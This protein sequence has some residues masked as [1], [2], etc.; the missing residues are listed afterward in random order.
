MNME[1]IVDPTEAVVQVDRVRSLADQNTEALGFLPER[2]YT[3]AALK[4]HLWIATDKTKQRILGY[5]LFGG[6]FPNLKVFQVYVC[7]KFRGQHIAP[8]L[9]EKLKDYGQKHNFMNIKAKVASELSANKFWQSMGFRII[10]QSPGKTAGR[11]N[12]LYCLELDVPSLFRESTSVDGK[13]TAL[14]YPSRPI[15]E[16]PTFAIDV[17]VLFDVIQDRSTDDAARVITFAMDSEIK[18]CVT[19]EFVRE[20]ENRSLNLKSDPV[21]ALA[22]QL[23]RL[24]KLKNEIISPIIEEIRKIFVSGTPKT[25]K[26]LA[27]DQSDFTH[28]ASCI[29]HRVHGFVTRDGAILRNAHK[30]HEKYSLRI[31]SPA[32]VIESYEEQVEIDKAPIAFNVD[33]REIVFSTLR[34]DERAEA[35]Q[36]LDRLRVEKDEALSCLNS[37]T[38]QSPR[39]RMIAR[40]T[41]NI[42]GVFS[43]PNNFSLNR[44]NTV[45]LYIDEDHSRSNHA[46]DYFLESLSNS[47]DNDKLIYVDLWILSTQMRSSET[48]IKRGFRPTKEQKGNRRKLRKLYIRGLIMDRQWREFSRRFFKLTDFKISDKM[49][50]YNVISNTGM[51]AERKG[52]HGFFVSTLF[53]F[54]TLISPGYLI[55]PGRPAVMIP[56]RESYANELLMPAISVRQISFLPNPEA[57]L[58]LERAYFSKSSNPNISRGTLVLFY[59]SDPRKEAVGMA[60]VTFSDRL[61]RTQALFNL[62]RQGVLS[63]QEMNLMI[64]NKGQIFAFTFDNLLAFPRCVPYRELKKLGCV[65]G[66]NLVTAQPLTHEQFCK[67]IEKAFE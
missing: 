61:T 10:D 54:E 30:I 52:N 49:P 41:G 59:V 18:L 51:I 33:E 53:D 36:F 16:N 65:G 66:A 27:N 55:A 46:I 22:K 15:L 64:D 12:N 63:E 60:R 19:H 29:H 11:T 5:L 37:G 4:G 40:S 62:R 2:A 39:T 21:L 45:H 57:S 20:L 31:Y 28:L 26:R 1:I 43:R 23:P 67:I 56:I 13:S 3:E 48:A 58:R 25:G 17:N 47:C 38:V 8:T 42:V 50:S 35:D 6:T 32:D 34:E 14:D 9:I 24:P 44:E 7:P